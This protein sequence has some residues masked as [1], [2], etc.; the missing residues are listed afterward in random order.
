[1]MRKMIPMMMFNMSNNV[2]LRLYFFYK[3]FENDD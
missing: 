2:F 3:L 1:M